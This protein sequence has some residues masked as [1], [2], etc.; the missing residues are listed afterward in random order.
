[1]VDEAQKRM[2]D[3]TVDETQRWSTALPLIEANQTGTPDSVTE[4]LKA[5]AGVILDKLD[6]APRSTH[7]TV[8]S[9]HLTGWGANVPVQKAAIN[10]LLWAQ[11]VDEI[12]GWWH[13]IP[14][15]IELDWD[16]VQ[17]LLGTG[18]YAQ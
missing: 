14:E 13:K 1:M 15:P 6:Y 7:G 5:V 17:W 16:D 4:R 8:L 9:E 12:N 2:A 18:R 10:G 11:K 3:G